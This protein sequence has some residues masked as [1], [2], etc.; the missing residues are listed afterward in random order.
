M[1]IEFYLNILLWIV[2]SGLIIGIMITYLF[3]NAHYNKWLVPRINTYNDVIDSKTLNSLIEEFRLMFNLKDYEI[4]FSDDLKPH[5]L[6][7]N[8]KKRQKQIIISKR[9]FESVGYELDY[10]ISRIWISAKEINKDNKIKNYKFVTKYITN[11]LLLLIVLFYLLQ[12]LIFFYCIS[13]NIDTIAQNSFIFFLWKNFIVAILVI[14]FTSMFI[15]NYLVAYR[16]KEKIELYYNY[17]ISNLV[18]IVFEQFEYDFRAARTY[19]QQIKIPIIFIFNQKHNK[20]LGP[21]V[22]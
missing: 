4:I 1:S 21:F 16:L 10:I 18:K 19:A 15:I 22:Y 11:T 8:L 12:S 3:F 13:K 6:F 2:D 20:W 5:K 17:E 7:W 14:I 9:I